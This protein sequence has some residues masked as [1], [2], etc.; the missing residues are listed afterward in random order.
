MSDQVP[1]DQVPLAFVMRFRC[2]SEHG[3]VQVIWHQNDRE[4]SVWDAVHAFPS[5]IV[6]RLGRGNNYD[7]VEYLLKNSIHH[8]CRKSHKEL[9]AAV[10]KFCDDTLK[11][12]PS[13]VDPAQL[14][15]AIEN[16]EAMGGL[17]V[18][19]KK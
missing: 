10:K 4:F 2:G 5:N 9:Y 6:K 1:S 12:F 14:A 18:N 17:I 19:R 11:R 16:L 15:K 13:L 3:I 8:L 7:G